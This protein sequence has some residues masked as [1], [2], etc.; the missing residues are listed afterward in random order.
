MSSGGMRALGRVFDVV[1]IASGKYISLANASAVTFVC[2]GADTFTVR[3]AKSATGTS[4]QDIGALVT[5]YYQQ[6]GTDGTHGWTLQTQAGAA[7]VTQGSAYTT[8]I[9]VLGA[10]LDDGFSYIYCHAAASGLVTAI[11]HDLNVQR[12][13]ANLATLVA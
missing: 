13:P 12:A 1:P 11:L 5:Q 3:E 4:V 6:A 7:A 9:E 8:V 10:Y 2:T